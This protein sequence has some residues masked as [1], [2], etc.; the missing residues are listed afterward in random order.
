MPTF[1]VSVPSRLVF[2]ELFE[3]SKGVTSFIVPSL[4]NNL[5]IN[6]DK[7][8]LSPFVYSS[9]GCLYTCIFF[10]AKSTVLGKLTLKVTVF[11]VPN[12]VVN[13]YFL[14]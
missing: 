11:P 13:A 2:I 5:T 3:K 10:T 12:P 6:S 8:N 14:L 7:S 9:L 4:Y 1:S